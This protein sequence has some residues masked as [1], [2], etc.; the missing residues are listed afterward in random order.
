MVKLGK[1]SSLYLHSPPKHK[2]TCVWIVHSPSCLTGNCETVKFQTYTDIIT[3]SF[4]IPCD[5]SWLC[6]WVSQFQVDTLLDLVIICEAAVVTMFSMFYIYISS[7]HTLQYCLPF[8]V[9]KSLE[10][11]K[12]FGFCFESISISVVHSSREKTLILFYRKDLC[13]ERHLNVITETF[14]FWTDFCFVVMVWN[15]KI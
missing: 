11:D 10:I 15:L 14:A 8:S 6:C 12:M 1:K 4:A 7:V 5:S 9:F 3:N 13:I 2:H